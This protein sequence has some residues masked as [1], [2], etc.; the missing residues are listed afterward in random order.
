MT[1]IQPTST[2]NNYG[3]LMDHLNS[4]RKNCDG[5][6]FRLHPKSVYYS[7]DTFIPAEFSDPNNIVS[8]TN[9]N[10][11]ISNVEKS[12]QIDYR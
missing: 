3:K 11:R 12:N 8:N 9:C 7:T 10:K 5:S 2:I 1:S 6:K 4:L